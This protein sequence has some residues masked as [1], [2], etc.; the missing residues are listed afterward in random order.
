MNTIESLIKN[1][2]PKGKYDLFIDVGLS[3]NAP[4]SVE[5][6]QKNPNSFVIGVEPNPESCK[7]I[8]QKYIPESEKRFLLLPYGIADVKKPE[9][10]KLNIVMP[11]PGTSSFL[12]I[13]QKFIDGWNVSLKETVEVPVVS[14]KTILDL[15]PWENFRSKNFDMK[16]DTQGFE[17]EVLKSLGDYIKNV[18][19]LKVES[20]TRGQYENAATTEEIFSFLGE[21]GLQLVEHD[22]GNA[23]FVDWKKI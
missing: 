13:T 2:I 10:K 12:D 8:R 23:W 22:G 16:S 17:Y 15:L 3:Y 4:H 5:K 6:L 9:Q 14:L 7:I 19:H 11:D 20:T 1:K 18:R 21:S